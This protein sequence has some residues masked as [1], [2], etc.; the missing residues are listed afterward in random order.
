MLHTFPLIQSLTILSTFHSYTDC[1]DELMASSCP[2]ASV[3][4]SNCVGNGDENPLIPGSSGQGAV[5][6]LPVNNYAANFLRLSVC[7][8]RVDE[9]TYQQF[10]VVR[11]RRCR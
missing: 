10:G 8:A 11:T 9:A 7:D 5:R 1:V 2:D 6:V 3:C 4:G